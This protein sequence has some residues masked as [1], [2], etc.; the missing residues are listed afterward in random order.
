MPG[1]A[2]VAGGDAGAG[3][4]PG[5]GAGAVRA[6]RL[7]RGAVVVVLRPAV[8]L[9][10]AVGHGTAAAGR[11]G[12]A[13]HNPCGGARGCRGA[14]PASSSETSEGPDGAG[15]SRRRSSGIAGVVCFIDPV[16]VVAAAA[17]RLP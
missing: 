5:V 6:G 11:R 7:R 13:D 16:T 9:P 17:R 12:T 15:P 14:R 4:N 10:W 2:A 8:G 1:A 3:S